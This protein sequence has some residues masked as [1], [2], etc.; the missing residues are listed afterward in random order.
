MTPTDAPKFPAPTP[1]TDDASRAP[2]RL[3]IANWAVI[4]IFLLMLF[5]FFAQARGFLM[6]VTLAFLLFF[7]FIP[8]RRL[9]ER[10]RVGA[11]ATAAMVSLGLV[12][13]VVVI[14]FVISG[15]I[16][17][18][19][20]N[21]PQISSRLEQRFSEVR[22][23]FKG[24]ERA[25]Q[26]LD[27][28]TGGS[29]SPEPGQTPRAAPPAN[30]PRPGVAQG[31]ASAVTGTVTGTVTS[32]P[33]PG[34]TPTPDQRIEVQVTAQ[35]T[36][37]ALGSALTLGPAFIGQLIF[38]L[39]LL[40]FLISSG[41]LLYLKIV[42]SFDRMRDKRAAYLALRAIEDRLGAY[43]SAIT[44][45]NA[46]LGVAVGIA[47]WAWGMP[48][49]VLFALA[50]FLLNFIPYLGSMGGIVIAMLVGVFV[51]DDLFTPL[52]V[53][54]T[55]LA[56]TSVEGQLITPY[57]VSRKLQLNTV[58]VFL[59][60]ALWAWLWSVLGMI[61]A[62]PLLVVLRVL[63]DYIPGLEKFGNFLGAEDPPALEGNDEDSD[64]EEARDLVE[65]G[66]EAQ[67]LGGAAAATRG[68]VANPN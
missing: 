44:V 66:E 39:F 60:V 64:E 55:Y 6:P 47:M 51:Y 20:D 45:I 4:G 43:L 21:A 46:C 25:A 27:E 63:S 61:V 68:V 50:A 67:T 24:I 7:V 19:I 59:T 42:Q 2:R 41:D 10:W 31:D 13:L 48:S 54:L 11:T 8:F 65:A 62:V 9:M 58:V 15:P 18:L 28:L 30:A 17:R 34:A 12:V 56:L 57:F 37:S 49:P 38:T 16:N 3:P 32:I 29:A 22:S 33:A 40:F 53:G 23:N 35:P 1:P 52:M 14:G 26:K 5:G 36:S